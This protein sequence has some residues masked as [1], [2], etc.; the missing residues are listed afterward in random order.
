[1]FDT[2]RHVVPLPHPEHLLRAIDHEA[3][4][5]SGDDPNIVGNVGM[6]CNVGAGRIRGEQHLTPTG[7]QP[8]CVERAIECIESLISGG[9]WVMLER[10]ILAP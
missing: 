9:K 3:Q 1:M 10:V 4:P 2:G 8:K 7:R 5:S 6:R